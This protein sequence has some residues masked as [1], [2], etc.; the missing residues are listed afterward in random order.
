MRIGASG[1]AT[2]RLGVVVLMVAACSGVW[3]LLAAQ[4][5]GTPLYIDTLAGPIAALRELATVFGLLLLGAGLLMPWASQGREPRRLVAALYAGTAL[6]LG[7]QLYAA[8]QGMYGVQLSD[9]RP[10]ALPLFV[11]KQTGLLLL[12]GGLLE[13][14]RRVLLRPPPGEEA[15]PLQPPHDPST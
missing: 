7:A 15:R 1:K 8:T 4:S 13:L 14:G 9:L 5:P 11:A 12:V 3:E 6:A 2:V 10:D